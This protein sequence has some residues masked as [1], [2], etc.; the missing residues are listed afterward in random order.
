MA[1]PRV[2]SLNDDGALQMEVLPEV[3]KLRHGHA[4]VPR[5]ATVEAQNKVLQST[6]IEDLAA[7]LI[8]EFRPKADQPFTLR[9]R[10]EDGQNF[11]TISCTNKAGGRELSVNDLK[12]PLSGSGDSPVR[13]H[14][15]LD[16]SVLE[17]FANGTTTL[18]ARIYQVPNWPL[19]VRL[20][21]VATVD[22][23]DIWRMQPISKDRL[24]GSLCS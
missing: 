20:E 10:S 5:H 19:V 7:E 4:N 3:H 22:S 18:T 11:A 15:F 23:L 24:T 8:L 17:V 12:A 21:G 6:R 1:L 13:L 14:L 16:G 9:L 2:L